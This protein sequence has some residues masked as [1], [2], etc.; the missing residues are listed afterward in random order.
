MNPKNKAF[1][2]IELLVVISIVTLLIAI[3]LPAL[4][5]ARESAKQVKCM[6]IV[7]GLTTAGLAYSAQTNGAYMPY[8]YK[9]VDPSDGQLKDLPWYN[10]PMFISLLSGMH[11]GLYYTASGMCPSSTKSIGNGS[12]TQIQKSYGYNRTS[13]KYTWTAT[14]NPQ[15][16]E[17]D[18]L[19]PTDKM[20]FADGIHWAL[21]GKKSDAYIDEDTTHNPGT[22]DQA[23]IAYRH[24]EGSTVG[25]YDG[26]GQWIKRSLLDISKATSLQYDKTWDL[27]VYDY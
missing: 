21:D 24:N 25:F 22:G 26:H 19:K 27:T 2:L 18:M 7:R 6:S 17:Y 1:T 23:Q 12:V 13:L 14:P 15:I 8:Y 4:A 16:Y 9:A 20:M 10:E 5:K 11:D 3:V